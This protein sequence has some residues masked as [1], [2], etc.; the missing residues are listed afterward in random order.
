MNIAS[1][2]FIKAF[3]PGLLFASVAIGSSHLVQSTR[4][5]ALYG[6]GMVVLIIFAMASKYP[7][8]R[9]APQYTAATGLSLL[10][11][12]KRQGKIVFLLVSLL[13]VFTGFVAIAALSS[14]TAGIAIYAF[15]I[16]LSPLQIAIAILLINTLILG[17]GRYYWLDI[18]MKALIVV[19]SVSTIAATVLAI[20]QI[21]WNASLRLMPDEIDR[22]TII[23][24][25]TL[26]GW[27]PAPIEA[28]VGLSL[29]TKAKAEASAYRP[30]VNE[31]VL[32]FHVGYAGTF[33][34]AVCF[35]FLGA[36][37]MR[38]P[39]I[40]MAGG[41][42]GF[43]RQLISIYEMTLGEWSG[44]LIRIATVAVMYSTLLAAT[45]SYARILAR[46]LM[47]LRVKEQAW[48]VEADTKYRFLYLITLIALSVGGLIVFQLFASS[49]RVLL[50]IATSAAFI[51][52]PLIAI[53]VHRAMTVDELS[54]AVRPGRG[55]RLYSLVCIVLLSVFALGYISLLL[56]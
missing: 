20:P 42:A 17:L 52:A 35:L 2:N 7:F 44:P 18:L 27:M 16:D 37:L 24:A 32:D 41:V 30:Q 50:G 13:M 45:D 29:W 21:D 31:S 22:A 38:G 25:V 34:L 14:G 4:A 10:D 33:F 46:I 51:T 19:L 43:T 53:L 39:D 8:Y 5:G 28:A 9:F 23:F 55:L 47:S 26:I 56:W 49:F 11:S 36:A 15:N 6:L 12:F 3:G 54:I 48:I 1:P 40:E